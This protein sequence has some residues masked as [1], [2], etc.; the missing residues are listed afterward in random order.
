MAF[1]AD[2]TPLGGTGVVTEREEAVLAAVGIGSVEEL[3]SAI[4]DN[5]TGVARVL[6]ASGESSKR[7]WL[8]HSRASRQRCNK[9]SRRRTPGTLPARFPL[10]DGE[11]S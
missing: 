1:D 2:L 10:R 9:L 8:E 11:A 5:P 7:L 4:T 3:V 6:G